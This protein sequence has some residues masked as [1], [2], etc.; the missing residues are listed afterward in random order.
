MDQAISLYKERS[1]ALGY[2]TSSFR[3][4][5][6]SSQVCLVLYFI[7]LDAMF[8]IIFFRWDSLFQLLMCSGLR[9]LNVLEL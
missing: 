4:H 8:K 6:Q 2:I 1:K 9:K 7:V 5:E 3:E